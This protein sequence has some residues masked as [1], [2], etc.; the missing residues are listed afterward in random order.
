MENISVYA[1]F[2]KWVTLDCRA[3]HSHAF[4]NFCRFC[5][6]ISS[7]NA[8]TFR[9]F[10]NSS[11]AKCQRANNAFYYFISIHFADSDRTCA[12]SALCRWLIA[13]AIGWMRSNRRFKVEMEIVG[14]KY[15]ESVG[16]ARARATR[17]LAFQSAHGSTYSRSTLRE[18]FGR[19]CTVHN[20]HGLPARG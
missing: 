1:S 12:I 3:A 10:P 9:V 8:Q 13:T 18:F 14:H 4:A 16:C 6:F 7:S 19:V 11:L 17:L 2:H 15:R 5:L 20:T